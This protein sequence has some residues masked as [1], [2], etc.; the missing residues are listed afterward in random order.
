MAI[1]SN[2]R[3]VYRCSLCGKTLDRSANQGKPEPGRCAKN[4]QMKGPHRWTLVKKY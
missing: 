3:A 1:S 4:N 2:P